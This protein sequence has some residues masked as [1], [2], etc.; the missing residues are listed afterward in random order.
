MATKKSLELDDEL[1]TQ[2]PVKY[3]VLLLNDDYSSMDFVIDILMTIFHRTYTESEKIM[4]EVHETQ[5]GLCGVYTYEIAET[6]VA[7][8]T[9]IAREQGFPLKAI[10]EEE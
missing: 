3:K 10:M 7:Q 8:V 9:K 4:L 6:K 2:E 1:L 5:R